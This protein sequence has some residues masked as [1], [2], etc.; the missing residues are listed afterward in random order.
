MPHSPPTSSSPAPALGPGL[1]V[2]GEREAKA[3]H[4]VSLLMTAAAVLSACAAAASYLPGMSGKLWMTKHRSSSSCHEKVMPRGPAARHTGEPKHY[5]RG[6][7]TPPLSLVWACLPAGKVTSARAGSMGA[8]GGRMRWQCSGHRPAVHEDLKQQT[9]RVETW[10]KSRI[11]CRLA[12]PV[13][14]KLWGQP[15]A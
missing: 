2:P 1:S 7:H 10:M 11:Q 4:R 15:A 3:I 9:I 6:I 12:I 5:N 13:N 8:S 14:S